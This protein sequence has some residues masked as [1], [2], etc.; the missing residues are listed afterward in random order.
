MNKYKPRYREIQNLNFYN[1]LEDNHH[2][3]SKLFLFQNL[4]RYCQ[5]NGLDIFKIVPITF[6]IKPGVHD[7]EYKNFLNYYK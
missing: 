2:L 7:E 6:D 1:H 5:L 3:T 4:R